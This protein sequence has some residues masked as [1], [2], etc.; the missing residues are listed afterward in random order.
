MLI[1]LAGVIPGIALALWERQRLAHQD[2][3]LP[4]ALAPTNRLADGASYALIL[5]TSV[6][7]ILSLKWFFRVNANARSLSATPLRVSPLGAVL[8]QFA[9]LVAVWKTWLAF[10]QC[11][12]TSAQP[13]RWRAARVPGLLYVWW[14]LFAIGH[15]DGL[16]GL[17]LGLRLETVAEARTYDLLMV[18]SYLLHVPLTAVLIVLVRRLSDQQWRALQVREF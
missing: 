11:W 16:H 9:P 13:D 6:A 7:M 14:A 10:R 8:W 4:Y 15:I 12:Q 5:V 18:G 2:P 3:L 17:W 1:D